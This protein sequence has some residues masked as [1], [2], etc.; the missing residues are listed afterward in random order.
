MLHNIVALLT[1]YSGV[2]IIFSIYC[3]LIQT[4]EIELVLANRFFILL[5]CD[6]GNCVSKNKAMHYSATGIVATAYTLLKKVET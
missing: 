2:E 6:K 1:Y 5:M 4:A 3:V